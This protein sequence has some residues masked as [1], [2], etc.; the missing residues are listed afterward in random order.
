MSLDKQT[1]LNALRRVKGP[2]LASNLVDLGLI[3]EVLIKEGKVFFSITVP[4]QRAEDLEPLRQAA[5]K[6]VSDLE[7]VSGV[8]V[9]LTAEKLPVFDTAI[10]S[11]THKSSSETGD[12]QRRSQAKHSPKTS[13]SFL[14]D[15]VKN[16]RPQDIPGVK[17]LI[18]IASGKGGVGKSTMAVNLAL[19]LIAQG[20][21]VGILD[22]DIYGP[23]LPRLLGLSGKPKIGPQKKIL[24]MEKYGLRAMSMGFMIEENTPIVWRGPMVTQAIHQ[25][26]REV[27]WGELDLILIDMPPGT[28][29]VQLSMAQQVPLAGALI[30]ST[31]QD[32]ALIDAKKALGMFQ[33]VHIPI[34]GI[35]ENMSYFLCPHCGER[36]DI[37][38]HGG[39]RDEAARLGV[40]FLGCI[41]LH[42]DIRVRSD[43][44][45]PIVALLPESPEAHTFC[46]VAK[47]LW[48]QILTSSSGIQMFPEL[49]I[50]DQG[51]TLSVSFEE[52]EKYLLPAELLRV[53]SP[54]AEVQGHS[55]HQRVTVAGKRTVLLQ[56]LKPVG[57]YAIRILFDDH[58]DT[59]L[60][61]WEYLRTLGR[62]KDQ[63]W[64]Q[65]LAD[66]SLK[67]LSREKP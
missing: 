60:Y 44:G 9:V 54:S 6:V 27:E 66:L 63:R 39:A 11:P 23:S 67:G 26:L 21:K 20:L 59:G 8:S 16:L 56:D 40:F 38:G 42:M 32:L 14:P 35:V 61:T 55:P 36:S 62:E 13:V 29:D 48:Q 24:P 10:S 64:S 46:N 50:I 37:F 30:V 33:K 43:T 22:A 57:N 25:M 31:P 3:S 15:T 51:A 18:A 28:G 41:P 5:E 4:Q 45:L 65:Y 52:T 2:D 53:L 49:L 1:I 12:H 34:L 58:H 7:G 19:G 47:N 17:H